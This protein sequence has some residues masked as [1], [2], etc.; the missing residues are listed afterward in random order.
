[1]PDLFGHSK[2]KD[3]L[4][5]WQSFAEALPAAD[6]QIFSRIVE[7]ASQYEVEIESS[8][9]GHDAEVF[10]LSILLAQQKKIQELMGFIQTRR[11]KAIAKK[12]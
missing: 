9:E 3:L 5:S 12:I 4:N 6:R 10:L 7:E 8:I 11:K 2:R 1:M